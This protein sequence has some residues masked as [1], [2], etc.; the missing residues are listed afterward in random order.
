MPKAS[1][2]QQFL[3]KYTLFWSSYQSCLVQ[4]FEVSLFLLCW[5]MFNKASRLTMQER[6]TNLLVCSTFL[7]TGGSWLN[8]T[9]QSLFKLLK[10]PHLS[11]RHCL[12]NWR[13]LIAENLHRLIM[14]EARE[15]LATSMFTLVTCDEVTTVE[16]EKKRKTNARIFIPAWL[17]ARWPYTDH[18]IPWCSIWFYASFGEVG[19]D[20][21]LVVHFC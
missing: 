18:G 5:C 2:A 11:V 10:M 21:S 3:S 4:W 7:A 20:G 16:K 9:M 17:W 1:I 12:D 8:M 14:H 6:W 13:L 19:S 15:V